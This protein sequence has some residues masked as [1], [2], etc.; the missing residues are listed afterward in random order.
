[1]NRVAVRI[2]KQKNGTY[3]VAGRRTSV[4]CDTLDQ[5]WAESVEYF[6]GRKW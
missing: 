2:S 5:A 3:L 6:A 1:M 4:T